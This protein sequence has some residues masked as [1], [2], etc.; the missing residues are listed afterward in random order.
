ML[1]TWCLDS[2]FTPIVSVATDPP[3]YIMASRN[4]NRSKRALMFESLGKIEIKADFSLGDLSKDQKTKLKKMITGKEELSAEKVDEAMHVISWYEKERD[5]TKLPFK[6][7][8]IKNKKFRMAVTRVI[9]ANKLKPTPRGTV[10]I[11]PTT[12]PTP[13]PIPSSSPHHTT[14]SLR[15]KKPTVEQRTSLTSLEKIKKMCLDDSPWNHYLKVALQ[16]LEGP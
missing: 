11:K 15:P 7:C 4:D 9:N 10:I 1:Y 12:T 8:N 13:T 14:P 16:S 2:V 6:P 3:A 5:K